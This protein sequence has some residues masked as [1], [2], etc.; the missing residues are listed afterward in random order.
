MICNVNHVRDKVP[1]PS[2]GIMSYFGNQPHNFHLVGAP[3]HNSPVNI[4]MCTNIE[5][6]S[7]TEVQTLSEQ[8]P[9]HV[10]SDSENARTEKRIMWT[11]EEDVRL[12]SS[13]IENST[14]SSCGADRGGNQYWGDV[15]ESYNKTTLSHWKRNLKQCKD[16]WHKINR[17]TDLFE[18]F[19]VKARK[20]IYKY[21]LQMWIDAAHKFYGGEGEEK[22]QSFE[23]MPKRP[24]GQKAAK[25]AALAAKGQ[26]KRLS[27][28]DDGNSKE[29]A[30]D[31]E[32]LDRFSKF[33]EETNANNIKVQGTTTKVII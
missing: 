11:G 21:L 6:S 14:E 29:S 8:Q 2:G 28:D 24:I 10:D 3:V 26:P 27:S 33:W 4:A 32:K 9:E 12:M 23:E 7:P 17:W 19:Y 31:L 15:V 5:G 13:W 20:S 18:C 30:I 16:R 22:D 1:R 25:K